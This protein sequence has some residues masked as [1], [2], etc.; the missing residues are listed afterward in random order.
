MTGTELAGPTPPAYLFETTNPDDVILSATR[1]AI[2]LADV[3]ER[4]HLYTEFR[5]KRT[6]K[7]RK[8]V[9]IEGWTLLASM[10]GVSTRIEYSRPVPNGWEAVASAYRG[11]ELIGNA[12]SMCTR[13]EPNW[14]QAQDYALRGMAQ[15][16]AISRALRIPLGMIVVLA[17]FEATP[18]EEMPADEPPARRASQTPTAQRL[19]REVMAAAAAKGI[20]TEGL[21]VIARQAG[22]DGPAT[23]AQM[24]AML[25]LIEQAPKAEQADEPAPGQL[26]IEEAAP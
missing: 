7:L 9:G 12:Q 6:G 24:R 11:A 20:D 22:V 10:L 26:T 19:R 1:Y 4:R 2:A 8:H 16:R 5:D 23:V 14:Q 25:V 18:T 3:I 17:G 21:A 13:D 15:T